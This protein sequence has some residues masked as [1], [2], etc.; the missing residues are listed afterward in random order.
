MNTKQK[1]VLRMPVPEMPGAY[2]LLSGAWRDDKFDFAYPT[3]SFFFDAGTNG[4]EWC[5]PHG[6][7][8]SWTSCEAND[9]DAKEHYFYDFTND[10]PGSR[11]Q[12]AV[13]SNALPIAFVEGNYKRIFSVLRR[14][15]GNEVTE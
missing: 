10:P 14:W 6:P 1:R 4:V 9:K 8:Q 13:D 11:S 7:I 15:A 2:I 12:L 5:P 3:V